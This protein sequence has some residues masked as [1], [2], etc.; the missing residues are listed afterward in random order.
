MR[1]PPFLHVRNVGKRLAKRVSAQ[2][3]QIANRGV[4]GAL[5]V[6]SERMSGSDM[7]PAVL[8]KVL[9]FSLDFTL[10]VLEFDSS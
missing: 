4:P 3:P 9:C 6:L 5:M 7:A 10:H 8:W 2:L 1:F